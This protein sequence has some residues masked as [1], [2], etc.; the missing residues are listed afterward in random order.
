MTEPNRFRVPLT[1]LTAVH[2]EQAEQ[3]EDQAAPRLTENWSG[4]LAT[5]PDGGGKLDEPPGQT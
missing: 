2:V 1:D 5:A 3:V 4:H